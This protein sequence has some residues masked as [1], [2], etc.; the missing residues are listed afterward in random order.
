MVK[1]VR[2]PAC[3]EPA[4]W[5]GNP[6]RP[7]CSSECKGVDLGNWATERY[8]IPAQQEPEADVAGEAKPKSE[9]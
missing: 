8:R 3:G 5:E 2:C 4:K 6:F 1:E 7:F 9:E